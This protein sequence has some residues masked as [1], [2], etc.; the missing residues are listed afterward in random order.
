[1]STPVQ[2]L[3]DLSG[4]TAL[5]TGGSRGI[6]RMIAEGFLKQGAKVYISSRKAAAC[7]ATAA[8]LSAIGPCFSLPADVSKQAG[9]AALVAA[10]LARIPPPAG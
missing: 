8:E 4:R 6:G 7:D 5:I 1:M 2:T 9:I 10:L 3:F